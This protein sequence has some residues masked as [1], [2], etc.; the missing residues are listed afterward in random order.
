MTATENS[1]P[2]FGTNS[3]LVDEMYAQYL[4]DTESVSESW[5]E[6]FSDYRGAAPATFGA[7]AAPPVPVAASPAIPPVTVPPFPSG[8][9][10]PSGLC[11]ESYFP[12]AK[13]A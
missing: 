2:D 10:A 6:F 12:A 13:A 5:R 7:H 11:R 9:S 1:A 3:W 4:S 8:A